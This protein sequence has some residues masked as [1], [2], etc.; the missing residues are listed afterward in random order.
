MIISKAYF[1]TF[2]GLFQKFQT[3]KSIK[4]GNLKNMYKIIDVQRVSLFA[5]PFIQKWIFS[6]KEWSP[7]AKWWSKVFTKCKSFA[8]KFNFS[9]LEELHPLTD[10]CVCVCLSRENMS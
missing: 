7:Q 3:Q 4:V 8:T 10:V 5:T 2:K 1:A 9:V 6:E